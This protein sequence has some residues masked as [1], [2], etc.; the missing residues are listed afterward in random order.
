MYLGGDSITALGFQSTHSQ[1][2]QC[3]YSYAFILT[4]ISIHALTR[5]AIVSSSRVSIRG[6]ISIHALTRSAMGQNNNKRR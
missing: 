4:N 3:R 2:V 6:S 5:S 1:G